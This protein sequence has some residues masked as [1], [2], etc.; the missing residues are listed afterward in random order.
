MNYPLIVYSSDMVRQSI[1]TKPVFNTL[2]ISFLVCSTL[3]MI[4]KCI[5]TLN[6]ILFEKYDMFYN[7]DVVLCFC[8]C[9]YLRP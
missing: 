3:D 1:K 9:C 5:E 6:M 4:L 7:W 8:L 2:S